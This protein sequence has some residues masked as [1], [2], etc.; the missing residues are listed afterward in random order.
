M[1]QYRSRPTVIHAEQWFPNKTV[2]GVSFAEAEGGWS[3]GYFVVT[4]H[5]QKTW[6]Q[7]G[8]WI[9]AEPSG[10]GHYPVKDAIFRDR[11]EPVPT[12]EGILV[13]ACLG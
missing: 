3:E 10:N 7:P 13:T 9:V 8:D 6:I 4:T 11:Y 1:S 5:G 12:A 2:P